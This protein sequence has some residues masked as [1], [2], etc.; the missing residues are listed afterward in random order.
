ML[1]PVLG[2][3]GELV[4]EKTRRREREKEPLAQRGRFLPKQDK[5][6]KS[7]KDKKKKNLIKKDEQSAIFPAEEP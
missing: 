6:K 4:S 2:R 1:F 7:E 5:K 3:S